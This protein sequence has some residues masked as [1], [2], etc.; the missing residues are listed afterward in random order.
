MMTRVV[1]TL[2][3]LGVLAGCSSPEASR[4]RGGGPGG[5]PGNH[6]QSVELHGKREMFHGTPQ[7]GPGR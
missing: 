5:D 4:T 7:K 1:M 3:A 2:F 6:G